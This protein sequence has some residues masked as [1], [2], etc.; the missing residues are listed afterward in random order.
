LYQ[1]CGSEFIASGS[2]S[3][4][5]SSISSDSRTGSRVLMTKNFRKDRYGK[6][7]N[8]FILSKIAIYLSLGLLEGSPSC[9]RSL[10]PS[11]ENIQH[12]KK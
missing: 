8:F 4:S 10:M 3:G 9:R 7:G 6:T 11:K 12:F 1:C 2:G 5:G